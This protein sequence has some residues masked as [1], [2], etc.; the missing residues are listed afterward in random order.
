MSVIRFLEHEDII[1]ERW[2]QC[3]DESANPLVYG[4]SWYLDGLCHQQWAGL[5]LGD[6]EAV[7]PLPWKKKFGLRYVYQPFF[8]QQLGVFSKN[9]ALRIDDFLN[10][11][12]RKFVKVHLQIHSALASKRSLTKRT[13]Y[14][15]DLS[16]KYHDIQGLYSAD[17]HKNLNKIKSANVVYSV[18]E[19]AGIVVDL[20]RQTWGAAVPELRE[21]HY[22]AFIT[23]CNQAQALDRLEMVQASDTGETL[24]AGLFLKSPKY[25]HYVCGAPTPSG[26]KLGIMHGIIDQVIQKYARQKMVLDFEGSEIPGVASFYRKFHPEKS[27]YLVYKRGLK[28]F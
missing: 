27:E 15:L 5:V 20:Y 13:N 22:N 3:I 1:P 17:C 11:I 14:L 8:C 21:Q 4:Y 9:T 25:L 19:N 28:L 10:A 26:K 24:G 23:A 7:F 12:P 2:D 16:A 6:Y 18:P